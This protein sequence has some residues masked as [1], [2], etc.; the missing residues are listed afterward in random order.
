MQLFR[1]VLKRQEEDIPDVFVKVSDA[2]TSDVPV[3]QAVLTLS[4]KKRPTAKSKT[5][6][7][8]ATVYKIVTGYPFL[9]LAIP[10]RPSRPEPKS[11][12]DGA[13]LL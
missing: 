13:S 7:E 1:K 12:R 5:T 11:K 10:T 2:A 8:G 6:P 4:A 3:L 9:C